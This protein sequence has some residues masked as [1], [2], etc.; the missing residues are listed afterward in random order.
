MAA[1][2][3]DLEEA[4]GSDE[5]AATLRSEQASQIDSLVGE[6]ETLKADVRAHKQYVEYCKEAA[7]TIHSHGLICH[8][9][10]GAA[11]T[12]GIAAA[13]IL[14]ILI[15]VGVIAEPACQH[16]VRGGAVPTGIERA[17]VVPRPEGFHVL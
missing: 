3:E 16:G 12:H 13:P 14:L 11:A 1:H 17:G 8:V 5:R 2:R 4:S 9:R 15:S 10:F 6:V 7:A